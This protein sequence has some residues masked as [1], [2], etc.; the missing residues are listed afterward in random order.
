MA[1]LS[2]A[3][4]RAVIGEMTQ[5]RGFIINSFAQIECLLA[6]LIDQCGPLIHDE[7]LKNKPIPFS[8]NN[9]VARV[10][11]LAHSGPLAPYADRLETLLSRFMEFEDMRHLFAHGFASF[12][13]TPEGDCGMFFTRYVPPPKGGEVTM[14]RHLY[15]PASMQAQR[16][17]CVEFTEAAMHDLRAIYRA[18]GLNPNRLATYELGSQA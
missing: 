12:T 10:R 1:G 2:E 9:R 17:S 13:H 11:E 15:R 18:L 3:E 16:E 8:A 14:V 4:V 5:D 6:D 7:T